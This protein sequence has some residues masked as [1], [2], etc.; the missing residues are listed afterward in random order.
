[1]SDTS[2]AKTWSVV[3]ALLGNHW[4]TTVRHGVEGQRAKLGELTFDV[5][6]IAALE[7]EARVFVHAIARIAAYE[8]IGSVRAMAPNALMFQAELMPSRVEEIAE[9]GATQAWNIAR[10]ML[11]EKLG[12]TS[13]EET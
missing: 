5:S 12:I 6:D 9:L 2:K 13:V 7:F 3:A 4:H 8:A 1:M 10:P 11:L